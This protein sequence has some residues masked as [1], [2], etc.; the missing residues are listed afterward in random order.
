MSKAA[1]EFR[2][3]ICSYN[4]IARSKLEGYIETFYSQIDVQT[5]WNHDSH[6]HK[7]GL[8]F[9]VIAFGSLLEFEG[10]ASK[11]SESKAYFEAAEVALSIVSFLKE[12]TIASVQTLVGPFY[13]LKLDV[14]VLIGSISWPIIMYTTTGFVEVIS[15]GL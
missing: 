10:S 7:L 2:L 5:S 11:C 15:H 14:R 3:T 8:L 9:I 1:P 4:V 12:I 13:A 6:P